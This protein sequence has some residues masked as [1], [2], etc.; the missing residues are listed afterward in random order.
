MVRLLAGCAV[1]VEDGDKSKS[2]EVFPKAGVVSSDNCG[3]IQVQKC[4]LG[5]HERYL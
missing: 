4:I 1:G 5:K 3:P 2:L